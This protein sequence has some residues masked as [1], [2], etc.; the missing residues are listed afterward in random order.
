M[1]GRSVTLMK[2]CVAHAS[3]KG[4]TYIQEKGID[5]PRSTRVEETVNTR[6]SIKYVINF[7]AGSQ[8][9]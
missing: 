9:R 2:A 5:A 3:T 7:S 8:R 6:V 4:D 1:F